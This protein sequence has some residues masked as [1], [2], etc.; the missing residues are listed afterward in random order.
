MTILRGGAATD[1]GRVRE[2][3]EDRYLQRDDLCLFAVADGV[4]GHQAGEVASQTS[5]ETI[6]TS[7]LEPTTEGLVTAIKQANDAVW[8]LAQSAAEKRGMGTTLAAVALVS[9]DGEEHLAVANVGDSRVYLFQQGELSQLTEDHSL[10]EELV[11]EG[12]ITREEARVH[13]QRSIITR[14]LGMDPNVTVDHLQLLPYEGDRLLLCSDGLTN[15]VTDESIESIL[16]RIGDPQEAAQE[17]VRQARANGG[18][19]NITVVVVDVVDD[20]DRSGR[21]STAL[22]ADARRAPSPGGGTRTAPSTSAWGPDP[23]EA[24]AQSGS[25]GPMSATATAPFEPASRPARPRRVTWRVVAF[26]VTLAAVLGVGI[27]AIGWYAR[28]T[29]YVGLDGDRVAIFKGR[30]GGLLWFDPTLQE[31]KPLTTRDVLQSRLPD[32]RAGR[33][34]PTK[35]A[36][37]RYVNNLRQEA[38]GVTPAPVPTTMVAPPATVS[39]TPPGPPTT[40]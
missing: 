20:D 16:R 29:Y 10:V 32:L 14:A 31:R 15:E 7:F 37:D 5:V 25:G 9:E 3:N 36:A 33:E 11:R 12:Q 21:A 4:G 39:S 34:E 2:I 27:V 13:P 24:P 23:G 28:N 22:G 17:L 18:N 19:D 26:L 40:L 6:E 8:H 38:A 1:V 35:A 30:P